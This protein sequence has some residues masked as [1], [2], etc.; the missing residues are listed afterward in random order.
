MPVLLDL[1]RRKSAGV[2]DAG[3]E[4]FYGAEAHA[5]VEAAGAGVAGGYGEGECGVAAR[6]EGLDGGVQESAAKSVT[7]VAWHHADLSGVGDAGRNCGS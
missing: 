3:G 1:A 7:L 5:F 4:R 6:A 2:G